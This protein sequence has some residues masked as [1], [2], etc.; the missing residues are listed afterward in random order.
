[1]GGIEN[2]LNTFILLP[3]II[4]KVLTWFLEA[5]LGLEK[6]WAHS[7]IE[8]NGFVFLDLP[9][10]FFPIWINSYRLWVSNSY[11]FSVLGGHSLEISPTLLT[12]CADNSFSAFNCC[13]AFP[14]IFHILRKYKA[15][16]F[17]GSGTRGNTN[18][19]KSMRVSQTVAHTIELSGTQ[20][21][22]WGVWLRWE[23]KGG[24]REVKS[25]IWRQCC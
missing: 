18:A 10:K 24:Q 22:Q 3:P 14:L 8:S 1:M 16:S 11:T 25:M 21:Y 13:L 9:L 7:V 6:I 17:S 2:S 15:P 20:S 5:V 12:C 19:I 4:Q 23:G